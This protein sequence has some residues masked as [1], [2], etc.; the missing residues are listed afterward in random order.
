MAGCDVSSFE[1]NCNMERDISKRLQTKLVLSHVSAMCGS[2]GM[3]FLEVD[4]DGSL[5]FRWDNDP[6]FEPMDVYV[7]IFDKTLSTVE[8]DGK[9]PLQH[10]ADKVF[11]KALTPRMIKY[12]RSCR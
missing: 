11:R 12:L 5:I 7:D 9:I 6:R 2:G 4:G 8:M 10:G 1:E 3:E